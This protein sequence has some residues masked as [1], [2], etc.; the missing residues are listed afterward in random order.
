MSSP[1][2]VTVSGE[3][4][5]VMLRL[6]ESSAVTVAA[7]VTAFKRPA[8]VMDAVFVIVDAVS[9]GAKAFTSA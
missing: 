4:L 7:A 6:A 9:S 2:S 8:P 3:R 1:F 5:F